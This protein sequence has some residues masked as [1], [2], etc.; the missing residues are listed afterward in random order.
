MVVVEPLEE[1]QAL[2]D[3]LLRQR[4]RALLELGDDAL[5]EAAH[6]P[7][8]VDR[9]PD[10]GEHPAEALFDL[11]VALRRLLGDL[12]VHQGFAA[13]SLRRLS[14]L[15]IGQKPALGVAL[16]GHDRMDDQVDL[17]VEPVQLRAHGVDEE[18]HVVVHDLHDRVRRAPALLF[19][20]RAVGPDLGSA[21]RTLLGETP[22]CQRRAVEVV[23]TDVGQVDRWNPGVE[24]PDEGFDRGPPLG[25]HTIPDPLQDA[26]QKV[27]FKFF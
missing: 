16:S 11:L 1:G 6:F 17:D 23:G 14:D 8:V 15:V 12:D 9:R 10:V 26:L 4:R 5:A 13:R 22:D 18:G 2:F 24:L 21:G 19:E 20:A 25:V 7:P 3:L 27:G